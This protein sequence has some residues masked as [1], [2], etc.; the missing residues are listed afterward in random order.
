MQSAAIKFAV[1]SLVRQCL[2]LVALGQGEVPVC[3]H[4][5]QRVGGSQAL[6]NPLGNLLSGVVM[7]KEVSSRADVGYGLS[8]DWLISQASPIILTLAHA[9]KL[10]TGSHNLCLHIQLHT[11]LRQQPA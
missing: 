11:T 10:D 1:Y 9:G 5:F 3:E 7:R 6:T 8:I 2:G 4:V